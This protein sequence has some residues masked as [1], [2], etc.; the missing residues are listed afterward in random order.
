ML[1]RFG[2]FKDK[3]FSNL[4]AFMDWFRQIMRIKNG[5]SHM[6]S[7]SGLI[8]FPVC[9]YTSTAEKIRGKVRRF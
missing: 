7:A 3:Q 1:T 8:R 5:V 2:S 4:F 6:T 9:R